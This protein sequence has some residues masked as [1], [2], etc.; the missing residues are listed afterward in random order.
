MSTQ[1]GGTDTL[2][3]LATHRPGAAELFERLQLDYCCGGDLSLRDACDQRELELGKVLELIAAAAPSDAAS[4]A[5]DL[6]GLSIGELCEHIVVTHHGPLRVAL[7]RLTK[8]LAT[9]SRV[10]GADQ[11]DL[12]D[13]ERTFLALRAEVEEHLLLEERTLFPACATL[14][15]GQA[16]PGPDDELLAH[17][18]DDHQ[19]V[20]AGLG[21]LHELGGAWDDS[22]ARCATHRELLRGLGTFE[23]DMHR[24]IHE[25]NNILFPRVLAQVG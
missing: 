20:G 9:V 11:P 24:H 2:G 4:P 5:D 13:L 23:R 25:E 7:A 21:R 3:E 6:R 17:L 19:A 10:H 14:D 8:L 22:R 16:R 18:R 1:A 12:H 15:G